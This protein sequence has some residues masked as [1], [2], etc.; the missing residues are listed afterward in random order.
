[1]R[2]QRDRRQRGDV[3]PG[4]AVRSKQR[5]DGRD[6]EQEVAAP[7]EHCVARALP[8]PDGASGATL[9]SAT[10][11]PSFP[12]EDPRGGESSDHG[13]RGHYPERQ[14]LGRRPEPG[15]EQGLDARRCELAEAL[16]DVGRNTRGTYTPPRSITAKNRGTTIAV[17]T[18]VVGA[19]AAINSPIAN[20]EAIPSTNAAANPIQVLR[21][22]DL[23]ASAPTTIRR[24]TDRDRV[25]PLDTGR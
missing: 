6:R 9:A 4:R 8:L 3:R 10:F 18:P 14:Q 7:I 1:M 13:D 15:I 11:G 17:A 2:R 23:E 5:E 24:I 19:T 20:S 12:A 22:R 16:E 25:R 21:P